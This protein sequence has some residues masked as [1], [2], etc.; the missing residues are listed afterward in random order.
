MKTTFIKS[1]EMLQTGG[2]IMNEV[3]T[4]DDDS[5]IVI[6]EDAVFYYKNISDYESGE[7]HI[8]YAER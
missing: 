2:Y 6:C 7:N 5:V 8:M 3:I 1:T 4:L